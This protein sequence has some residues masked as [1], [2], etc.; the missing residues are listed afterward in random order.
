M[1]TVFHDNIE[2]LT[3]NET[4]YRNV[5]FTTPSKEMQ[6]VTMSLKPDEDIGLEMHDNIDQFIRIEKGNGIVA[7]GQNGEE[8][9]ELVDGSAIIIPRGT[10]HNVINTSSTDS[11]NLYSIYTPASHV[12]GLIEKDKP[13]EEEEHPNGATK[14]L[15]KK[16]IPSELLDGLVG[17]G[18]IYK[19]NYSIYKD[20]Y[21]IYKNKYMK[22][23]KKYLDLKN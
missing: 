7:I 3:M 19:Q 2:K 11:L 21:P 12:E 1:N 14:T 15:E 23:K 10:W 13:L 4:N 9:K 20:K 22:Y 17:G 5:L 8:T 6:L 18:S 16:E